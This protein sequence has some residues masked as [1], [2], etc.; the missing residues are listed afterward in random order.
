MLQRLFV[1]FHLG[2]KLSRSHLNSGLDQV[3]CLK[4]KK[5][6]LYDGVERI[7]DGKVTGLLGM[8][9]DNFVEIQDPLT[10]W[11]RSKHPTIVIPVKDFLGDN[12]DQVDQTWKVNPASAHRQR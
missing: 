9:R 6:Y 7:G 8:G 2:S 3:P 4:G 10:A 5:A 12:P 11:P 1:R